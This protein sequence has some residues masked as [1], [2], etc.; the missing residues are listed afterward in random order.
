MQRVRFPVRY[1]TWSIFGEVIMKKSPAPRE[2]AHV[3]EEGAWGRKW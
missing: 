1:S 2:T 3:A